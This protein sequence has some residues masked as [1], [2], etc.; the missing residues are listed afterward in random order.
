[1]SNDNTQVEM[2]FW[3][4]QQT[5]FGI[6]Y[7]MAE[8]DIG[9]T[10]VPIVLHPAYDSAHTRPAPAGRME[11]LQQLFSQ[12]ADCKYMAVGLCKNACIKQFCYMFFLT[13]IINNNVGN[14]LLAQVCSWQCGSVVRTSV[15]NWRTFP[16]LRLI[17][18]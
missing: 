13:Q 4:V 7:L 17:Y 2:V 5:D 6:Y 12:Y 10:E 15:F 11:K 3:S 9:S 14:V 1:M 8:N 16:D 18:G